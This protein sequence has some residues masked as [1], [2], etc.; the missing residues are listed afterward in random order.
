[1]T[2]PLFRSDAYARETDATVLDAAPGRIV[3]D[4]TL[5]YPQG[6]GQPGDRGVFRLADGRSL[7]I[8]NTTYDSDR[9]T[10]V[11]IPEDGAPLLAA[12]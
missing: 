5:F 9:M 3:L 10:I 1:M 8:V 7:K 4:K 12:G 6:G 2:E 11:H